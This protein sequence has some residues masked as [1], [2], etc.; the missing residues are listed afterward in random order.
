[1]GVAGR[2]LRIRVFWAAMIGVRGGRWRTA[3]VDRIVRQSDFRTV[4]VAS[5]GA[6]SFF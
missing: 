5:S 3:F 2:R 1:M 6:P 4:A